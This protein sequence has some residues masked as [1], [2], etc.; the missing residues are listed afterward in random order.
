[1]D[2]WTYIDVDSNRPKF[3]DFNEPEFLR[4]FGLDMADV[5]GD[6]FVDI[7]SGRLVYVNPGG[8]M[9]GK[10]NRI[11]MDKNVDAFC[12]VDVD[13]D[14]FA[15]VIGMALPG[16]YWVEAQNTGATQWKTMQIGELPKA[17]HRNSQGY[18]KG[19]IIPGGKE[20]VLL[21]CG[22]GIWYFEIPRNPEAGDWPK[23]QIDAEAADEGFA[24][25]D[26]DGDGF[27]DVVGGRKIEDEPRII[28]FLRNPGNGSGNWTAHRIGITD[29]PAD[30]IEIGDI[31]GDG[32]LDVIVS[33]ERWQSKQPDANLYWFAQPADGPT[34]GQWESHIVVTEYSLNNLDVADMDNDGD[35][36]IVTCE[37]KGPLG[38]FRLQIF[39][40][41][42]RGNFTEHI[43]DRGKE[44]HLGT[45]LGDLDCDGDLDIVSIAWDYYKFLHVWRNDAIVK[46]A[47][48]NASAT[49]STKKDIPFEHSIIDYDSPA[50]PWAKMAGDIDGDEMPDAVV[51]GHGGPL[52]L[53]LYPEWSKS[54]VARGGYETVDGEL[55]DM[56]SDGD[57]DIVMGGIVWY[58]NPRPDREP[59]KGLW[60]VHRVV[61]HPTHDVEL[62][63]VDDDGDLD[64]ITR[65]QSEF[66][67][68][69]GNTI[70]V[71]IHREDGWLEQ[72]IDCPHG[73]GLAAADVDGDGDADIVTGGLWYENGAGW[74]GWKFAVWHRNATVA[75]ADIN[76]DGRLD[77]VL[78]P[79]ELKDQFYKISWFE[80]PAD[81]RK[82]TWTEHVVADS[83]ECV[84][85][86]LELG[87]MDGDGD[88]DIV[89]AEMHQGR[90]PDEVAI[91]AN[92]GRGT[93]W[94]KQVLSTKGSHYIRTADFGNDGDIDIIGANHA[95]DY[96]PVEIWENKL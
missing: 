67:T 85:H 14:E 42:G 88:V 51:G 63:D 12:V 56:D 15:D 60:K 83:V 28:T 64:I 58:E 57:L 22:E 30:R 77:V 23:T 46:D 82:G 19:Q 75:T 76:R 33:E 73:E 32:K 18:R 47:D 37:H 94:D 13:G 8:D 55:G 17:T 41:D 9:T 81:P 7:V 71:W 95:G 25:G 36:D 61:R 10:W 24:V 66:G 45:Q 92:A 38:Q 69:A 80:A 5:T 31:D 11:S 20:E 52:L 70:H 62:A 1:L 59:Q 90:D 4:Y 21:A 93:S 86:A 39:E 50:R 65:N 35:I 48:K 29:H 44:S 2:K 54:V 89:M 6:G 26:I 49:P 79:S 16:V 74:R 87:D 78:T 53:Y 84:V 27:V 96:H 34:S 72:I 40:N 68:E 43:A 3:G 91:Y